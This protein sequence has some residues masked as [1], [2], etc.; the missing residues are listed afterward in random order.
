MLFVIQLQPRC[1]LALCYLCINLALDELNEKPLVEGEREESFDS[2]FSLVS[3]LTPGSEQ[4]IQGI[5]PVS[6][7]THA[8]LFKLSTV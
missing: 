6:K 3:V 5:R 7:Y 8:A 2:R 4:Y 1:L